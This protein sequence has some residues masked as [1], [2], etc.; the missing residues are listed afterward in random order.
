MSI[1][2]RIFS[3]IGKLAVLCLLLVGFIAGMTGVVYMS[4]SG[5]E[6]QVPDIVGKDFVESE[7]ELAAMGLKIKKRA[8]RP[9]TEKI[10]TVLEQSPKAGETLKTGNM[11]FVVVSKTGVEGETPVLPKKELETDDSEKIEEMISEKPKKPKAN[12]NTS[13]KKLDTSRDANVNESNSNSNS[14]DNSGPPDAS[15]KKEVPTGNKNT[16]TTP[17][18]KPQTAPNT[19]KPAVM[20]PAGAEMHPK[21]PAMP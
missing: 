7:K 14:N 18:V 13:K 10:N 9:S 11:I 12:T 8:D 4:L 21:Q 1:A 3:G 2:S 5:S 6:V 20:K 19:Q 16:S 15:D 17:G